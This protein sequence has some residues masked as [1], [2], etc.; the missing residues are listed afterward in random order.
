[1]KVKLKPFDGVYKDARSGYK[2]KSYGIVNSS[3]AGDLLLGRVFIT[4]RLDTE[5]KQVG[6]EKM[7]FT[8]CLEFGEIERDI[9]SDYGGLG[10]W[11]KTDTP[12]MCSSEDDLR[13]NVCFIIELAMKMVSGVIQPARTALYIAGITEPHKV[14][15]NTIDKR[16]FTYELDFCKYWLVELLPKKLMKLVEPKP[17]PE[18]K[19][20]Y[21]VFDMEYRYIE[22]PCDDEVASH[23]KCEIDQSHPATGPDDNPPGFIM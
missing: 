14:D 8:P 13:A 10:Y 7:L 6:I 17:E 15:S 4:V 18:A 3:S 9:V 20:A 5:N 19:P 21:K 2:S 22:R 16:F 1:M 23:S 12:K 11:F